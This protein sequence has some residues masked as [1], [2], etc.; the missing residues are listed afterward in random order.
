[1]VRQRAEGAW[2]VSGVSDLKR[3]QDFSPL[4]CHVTAGFVQENYAQLFKDA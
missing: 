4:T 3:Y 1:M 2:D